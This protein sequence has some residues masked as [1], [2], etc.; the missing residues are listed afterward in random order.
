MDTQNNGAPVNKQPAYQAPQMPP[1]SVGNW[2]LTILL[3]C[4]PLVGLIM[5][6]V[7]AFG[8]N[9][10]PS[11]RNWARAQLIWM[12]IGIICSIVFGAALAGVIASLAAS[13]G[14]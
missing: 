3:L 14:I 11:K 6:F 12:L 7:W 5:L 8:E 2:F 9:T 13:A 4:I 1:T 10:E